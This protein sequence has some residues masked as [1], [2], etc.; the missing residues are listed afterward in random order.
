MQHYII[1]KDNMLIF[2]RVGVM[3]N[4][5]ENIFLR[6][7]SI[8]L[9][10]KIYF[11]SKN[12]PG[13]ARH[14]YLF[15]QMTKEKIFLLLTSATR[16]YVPHQDIH[17]MTHPSPPRHRYVFITNDVILHHVD[18]ATVWHALPRIRTI[19][20]PGPKIL[21]NDPYVSGVPIRALQHIA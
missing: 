20:E 7:L 9:G 1:Q 15:L 8:I 12:K 19:C 10:Q 16:I 2:A 17:I 13:G 18:L 5:K 11:S 6:H 3:K 21:V 4:N 14:P